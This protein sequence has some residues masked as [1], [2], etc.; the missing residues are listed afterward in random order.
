MKVSPGKTCE[1]TRPEDR[2]KGILLKMSQEGAGFSACNTI[3][4]I[5]LLQGPSQGH[6]LEGQVVEP[7]PWWIRPCKF[8]RCSSKS[9][10]GSQAGSV[11]KPCVRFSVIC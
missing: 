8:P 7:R 6:S 11:R 2:I 9:R 5:G 4:P 3:R 10:C 1:D